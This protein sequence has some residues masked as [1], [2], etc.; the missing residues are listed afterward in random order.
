M[1][2][3]KTFHFFKESLKLAPLLWCIIFI[4]TLFPIL[5]HFAD[6]PFWNDIAMRIMLLGIGAIGL[7]IAFGFGGMVSL[8]HALFIGIGA[9]T[10]GIMNFYD[11]TNAFYHIILSILIC[12]TLGFLV[13]IL[14]LRTSGIYFIM[15]T[16]AFAQMF[17]FF[18]ISLE[19][20]GGDDGF[21][22]DRSH[23]FLID[24]YKNLRLYYVILSLLIITSFIS[25][26]LYNSRFGVTLRAIKSNPS[27][28]QSLGL[29]IINFKITAF[30]FSAIICGLSGTLF[31]NWQE[32][33][34]PDIMHWTKSGELLIVIVLG[35]LGTLSGPL[36]GSIV[37]YLLEEIIP[38]TL[39]IFLPLYQDNWMLIFG[40]MLIIIIFYGKGGTIAIFKFLFRYSK[41]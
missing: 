23:F 36:I 29:K 39:S 32:Y 31:A 13:G 6:Q 15:I 17:Y 9:Y 2:I 22:T 18:F 37:F 30:I 27:R 38:K 4:L 35:G 20:F 24:I 1:N 10:V 40:P 12:G 21:S 26:I 16:L 41:K 33:I 19:M 34:S 25:C 14:S 5:T 11:I 7:N 8:G 3:C 28:A